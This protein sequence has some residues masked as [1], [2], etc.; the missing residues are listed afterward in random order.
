MLGHSHEEIENVRGALGRSLRL[1]PF[2]FYLAPGDAQPQPKGLHCPIGG[3][4]HAGEIF[5]RMFLWPS[6][7]GKWASI[8]GH[9]ILTRPGIRAA[10]S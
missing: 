9:V 10:R 8:L 6:T 2:L 3:Q 1:I 5:N 7:V 4:E